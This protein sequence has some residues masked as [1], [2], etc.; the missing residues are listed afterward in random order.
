MIGLGAVWSDCWKTWWR[1][2]AGRRGVKGV[3][4]AL[5]RQKLIRSLSYKLARANFN[6]AI[7]R[8]IINIAIAQ[9]TAELL[10]SDSNF[11]PTT[12]HDQ[13]NH[14]WCFE[15]SGKDV[16]CLKTTR[17]VSMLFCWWRARQA[18]GD[19]KTCSLS[20]IAPILQ[21][22]KS[23][24]LYSKNSMFFHVDDSRDRANLIVV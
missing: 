12:C 13:H 22:S 19:K 7:L 14:R 17:I 16:L 4:T 15:H 5:L 9:H 20:L 23:M 10:T 11:K 2:S 24:P 8:W 1:A 18:V 6:H 21:Q 3:R